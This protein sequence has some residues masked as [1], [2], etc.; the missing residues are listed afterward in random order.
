MK[1]ESTKVPFH[2]VNIKVLSE[3][4]LFNSLSSGG[5]L[6]ESLVGLYFIISEG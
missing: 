1:R 3:F 2:F 4:A 5:C 6:R